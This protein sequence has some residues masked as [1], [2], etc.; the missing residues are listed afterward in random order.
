M[1]AAVLIAF[2]LVF[3]VGCVERL[4]EMFLK[5]KTAP[6]H[7]HALVHIFNDF[8]SPVYFDV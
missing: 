8:C 1:F 6:V 7:V 4:W 5:I 2:M 3:K